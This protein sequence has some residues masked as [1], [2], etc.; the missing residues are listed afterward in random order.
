[1]NIEWDPRKALE[2][3][4]KHNVDFADAVIS[5]EDDFALTIEDTDNNEQRFK[6]LGMGP[7]LKILFVVYA[8]SED[9]VI[10]I[11]SARNADP[12]ET[13]YYYQGLPI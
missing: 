2:N 9:D 7:N 12:G 4:R 6:T 11:I 10:R 3:V 8:Y 5:L 1:M 13:K